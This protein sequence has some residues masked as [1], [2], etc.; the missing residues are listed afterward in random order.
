MIDCIGMSDKIPNYCIP[1]CLPP[2]PLLCLRCS[3]VHMKK[4]VSLSTTCMEQRII[5]RPLGSAKSTEQ[6][7]GNTC[8]WGDGWSPITWSS[9]YQIRLAHSELSQ[10]SNAETLRWWGPW[11]QKPDRDN[12]WEGQA[13]HW[14]VIRALKGSQGTEKKWWLRWKGGMQR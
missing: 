10:S 5:Y 3:T 2:H 6:P 12:G 8:C 11:K 9:L 1:A 14:S 13:L 7:A 4:R